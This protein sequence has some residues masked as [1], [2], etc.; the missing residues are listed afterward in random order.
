MLGQVIGMHSPWLILLLMFYFLAIAKVAEPLLRMHMPRSLYPIR[1]WERE[2][3]WLRRLRVFSFGRVL[4]HTPLRF[5][6]SNVYLSRQKRDLSR[7]LMHIE[8]AEATHFWAAVLFTPYIVYAAFQK[9]WLIVAVF[10]IVQ[11]L[12]NIYPILHLRYTRS[13]LQRSA[14]A[15]IRADGRETLS[16]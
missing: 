10:L 6:N 13:R 14:R 16:H 5:C 7:V 2:G 9:L 11:V 4:R 1:D 15:R 8:S 3:T 12:F